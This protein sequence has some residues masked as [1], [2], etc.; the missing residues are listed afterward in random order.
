MPQSLTLAVGLG[1]TLAADHAEDSGQPQ[2]WP[3]N[4]KDGQAARHLEVGLGSLLTNGTTGEATGL[5][6]HTPSV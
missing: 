6:C 4:F 5:G 3:V 2:Q 1:R